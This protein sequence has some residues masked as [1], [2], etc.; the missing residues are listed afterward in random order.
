MYEHP[1]KRAGLSMN[2]IIFSNKTE[3]GVKYLPSVCC[4]EYYSGLVDQGVPL[5]ASSL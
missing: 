3:A 2:R 1:I 4:Q 5:N